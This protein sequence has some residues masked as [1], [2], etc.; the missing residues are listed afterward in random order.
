MNISVII[1]GVIA[2]LCILAA[3]RFLH[4]KRLIDDMPTSKT[5]GVFIGL[6][7]LK[8]RAESDQPL[9][10]FLAARQ[11]VLYNWKVEEHWSRTVTTM[12]SKGMQTRHESGWTTV[13]KGDEMPPFYLKD[14]M[15]IIRIL[16]EGAEIQDLQIFNK[17]VRH[18]DP[19]YFS[20]GPL[21]EIAN[22]DHQRRFIET[23][24]LLHTNLYVMGQARERAD[25]VAAEIARDK[26]APMFLISSRTEKQISSGLGGWFWGWMIAGLLAAAG[27]VL[28][29]N[30]VLN[31]GLPQAWL[32]YVI[33]VGGYLFVILLGWIWTV[34]NSLVNLQ[35]RVKQGWSQVDIQLKRRNDLIPNLVQVVEGY[36][37]HEQGLQEMVTKLRGQLSATPPG[38]AGPDYAGFMPTLR[39]VMENYPELKASELFLK[40]QGELSD[41][42][43]RIAL[44]RDYY[45]QIVT[46]YNT[47]LEIVPDT[48][49]AKTMGLKPATL[50]EAADFERAPVVVHLVSE[51]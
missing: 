26:K 16:P 38:V 36:A 30:L 51:S 2:L 17:T 35:Q 20:K 23:A 46:F 39:V 33:A 37:V 28:I 8:G 31:P 7:E 22:S 34:F 43:Q 45:N 25:I 29:G 42:E 11:C 47:R 19:L 5:L 12:T 4:K 18:A 48:F 21:Q 1:G 14:D 40:L 32:P 44:A 27:G 41:T 6:A 10:S 15:G 13:A 49:L 9:T 24:I 50:M 3:F